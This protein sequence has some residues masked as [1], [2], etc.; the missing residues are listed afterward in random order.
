VVTSGGASV[1]GMFN[2]SALY[3]DPLLDSLAGMSVG[4]PVGSGRPGRGVPMSGAK[5]GVVGGGRV[6]AFDTASL[7]SQ[8]DTASYVASFQHLHGGGT[9]PSLCG[10]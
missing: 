2:T 7:K 10:T 9:E 4:G 8:D 3:N 5:A 1:M 6:S